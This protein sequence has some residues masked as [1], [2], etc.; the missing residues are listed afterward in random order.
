MRSVACGV[1]RKLWMWGSLLGRAEGFGA[2]CKMT[3]QKD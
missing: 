2:K 1:Q 3:S